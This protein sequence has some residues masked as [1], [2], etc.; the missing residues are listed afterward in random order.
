MLPSTFG[1]NKISAFANGLILANTNFN[2]KNN[3]FY[4]GVPSATNSIYSSPQGNFTTL[5]NYKMHVCSK[6]IN[7][8]S[9]TVP[10]LSLD[11]TN[12]NYLHIN[13]AMPSLVNNMGF[14][15]PEITLDYDGDTRSA[16]TPDIGA[17]ELNGITGILT[18]PLTPPVLWLKADAGVYTDAGV[19]TA[20]NGQTVQ[21]WN[22]QSCNGFNASQP[23][24]SKRPAWQQNAFN[25]KPALW[26]DGTNGNYWLENTVNTPVA[27]TG[28]ART[29]FV[30]AKAACSA[31]GT[32]YP[33]G[34]LFT[35][36][37]TA[38]ASTLEFVQNGSGIFHGGN[39]CSNHPEATS[40]NFT[41]GQNQ[42]FV[43]SWRTNG[44]GSNLDF[45]FNGIAA[46]TANANFI[47]DNGSAGY[48]IGDRR[49][50][51]QF[52]VPTGRYD[53][54]GHI[55]EIIVYDRALTDGERQSVETY[56]YNKY[57]LGTQALP[58][59]CNVKL[60]LKADTG[61]FTDAGVTAATNGQDIQQWNDQSANGY[62]VTQTVAASKPIWEQYAFNGKPA[63]FFD[64]STGDK[65][66]NNITQNLVGSGSARTIFIVAQK[67]CEW[68]DGGTLFSFRK[69]PLMGALMWYSTGGNLYTYTDGQTT[70]NNATVDNSLLNIAYINPTFFTYLVPTQNAK[71]DLYLNGTQQSVSQVGNIA[72]ENGTNGFTVGAR[73]DFGSQGWK[74]WIAEVIV[75][76]R[77]LTTTERQSVESYLQTKYGT[78]GLPPVFNNIPSATVISNATQADGTWNHIY[79]STDNSK[80]IASVKD[81]CLALGTINSTVYIDGTA[82][83]YN[84]QRYMRRHYVIN[85]ATDPVGTKRVRLYYTNADFADL[86]TYVP[87]LTS[88]SQLVITKYDGANEDGV[89]DPTGGTVELLPSSQITTGTVFGVNY[90]E[91]DVTG[92]SEF[93]I[94]TGFTAL[95]LQF[96]SFSAQKCNSNQVCLNWKTANEQNVSHFEIERSSDGFVFSKI[97]TKQ[98]SNQ[99]QNNYTDTDDIS[100]VQTK[101]VYYRI[102]QVDVNTSSKLSNVQ[103]I[104]L[105]SKTAIVIYP[106]PVK[107]EIKITG[108]QKVKAAQLMDA[109]GRVI[110]QWNINSSILPINKIVKGIYMLQLQLK[111]GET[112]NQKILKE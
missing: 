78:T 24:G 38:C 111:T 56:L 58:S 98:A 21:Q 75:Y 1:N 34:H 2:C 11:Y 101:Q 3:L 106:N 95:P 43:G 88:A 68:S 47:D 51:F 72:S 33:G 108:W 76:D 79:N 62:N 94:H 53:W 110:M 109:S 86:Q 42:P 37:R 82:G 85:P 81:N 48:C 17:D 103:Q 5:E 50:A 105:D 27:T 10:F 55:A 74:G 65:N 6:D 9:E 99:Q 89:F 97:G 67:K 80:V 4:A 36:R 45:W 100:I 63:L 59:A 112:Q 107:D 40:V 77:A 84:G 35:N 91:F 92:F 25:G 18:T 16:T 32:Y 60:W 61:V 54:Q 71:I 19:T 41:S 66:L 8:V 64:G 30:V 23:D 14:S 22:D 12:S 102:K 90:L 57:Q 46:T 96:I 13:P 26:F 69:T 73:E 15:T 70:T 93:W 83:Q 52:D 49:D 29:Y 31:T 87:T 104:N 28:S 44:T 39:L 20:T 7:S